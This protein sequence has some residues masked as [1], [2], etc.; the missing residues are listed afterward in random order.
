MKI[1]YCV[2]LTDLP[3]QCK[4]FLTNVKLLPTSL[5]IISSGIASSKLLVGHTLREDMGSDEGLQK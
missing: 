5:K 4:I 1:E 3:D 2:C